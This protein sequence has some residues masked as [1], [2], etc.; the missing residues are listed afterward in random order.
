MHALHC[1][2]ET[3]FPEE[4]TWSGIDLIP[5]VP[6]VKKTSSK[7][8]HWNGNWLSSCPGGIDSS[9]FSVLGGSNDQKVDVG[10]QPAFQK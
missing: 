5:A 7:L 3:A 2:K 4:Q 1:Y 9:V 6:V 8:S 10:K